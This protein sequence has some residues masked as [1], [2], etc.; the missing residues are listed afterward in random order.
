M[1]PAL[2]VVVEELQVSVKKSHVK[3]RLI[4]RYCLSRK[5]H[6]LNKKLISK[7]KVGLLPSK[8][9]CFICV[10]E[11][12]LKKNEKCFLFHLKSSFRSQGIWIVV[13]T[14]RK[15]AWLEYQFNIKFYN[16]TTWMTNNY[17]THIACISEIKG[18]QTMD[19]GELIEYNKRNIFI[20]KLCRKW[21]RFLTSLFF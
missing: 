19:F 13:L 20:Q 6:M 1:S 17:N 9:N 5:G 14:F 3:P 16:V 11:S 2:L 7:L 21:G 10:N 18:N 4:L 15:T 12:P 8:K